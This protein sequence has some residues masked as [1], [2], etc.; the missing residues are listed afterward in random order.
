MVLKPARH[1]AAELRQDDT[2][3]AGRSEYWRNYRPV[4]RGRPKLIKYREPL[5]ISGHGTRIR[6]DHNTLLIRDGF[7]HYPQ[8]LEEIRLFPGDPNLPNRIIN[9]DGSGGITFDALNWMTDQKIAFIQLNWRGRVS[10]SG[11]S[12]FAAD[13]KLVQLQ[14]EIRGTQKGLAINR[15]L[16]LAKFDSCVETLK[17]VFPDLPEAKIAI[18]KIRRWKAEIANPVKSHSHDKILGYEGVA[19]TAYHKPWHELPLKWS[20]LSRRPI[21][22]DWQKVGPRS[23]S[24]QRGANNARHPLNAMLNYGYAILISQVQ[25]AIV[26]AGFDPSIGVAHRRVGNPIPL[27][28]DL[29]EPLRPVVDRVILEFAL[30]H[31]F[32]PGDFTINRLGGCRLNPQMAKVVAKLIP[33]LECS[34]AIRHFL[35]VLG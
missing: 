22:R 2:E 11:N 24:W 27:V 25:T 34:V 7:T 29:M 30:S 13:P 17:A 26:A 18:E 32:T 8:K 19:A 21:P 12:G 33:N 16:I 1:I 5:I 9:L 15:K 20:G 28:Y 14:T 6:V 23:M 3:W 4:T 31:T 10:F 35:R